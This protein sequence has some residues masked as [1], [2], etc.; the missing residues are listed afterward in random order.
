MTLAR[1]CLGCGTKI[2]SGSRCDNCTLTKAKTAARGYDARWQH[3]ARQ[4]VRHHPWCTDC[5]TPD[6]PDN[7]LTG[8]HLRWPALTLADIEVV[9]RRCNSR[10]GARRKINNSFDHGLNDPQPASQC[11]THG[12]PAIA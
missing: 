12:G 9:C 2:S 10:R 8:D 1:P 5:G 7:P 4:A 11:I 3:L 6:T